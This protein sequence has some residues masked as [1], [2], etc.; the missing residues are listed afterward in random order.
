MQVGFVALK[1]YRSYTDVE[2]R[3][4]PGVNILLGPNGVG[5]TN[6]AEAVGY[7]STCS[8]HRV[9]A[10]L[11]LVRQGAN[12]A[13]I[14]TAAIR[15]DRQISLEIAIN[16]GKANR[17]QVSGSP[18]RGKD[19]VGLLRTV[20]FAPE[21]LALAKGD[22][23]ERRRFI[24]GVLIQRSPRYLSIKTDYDRVVRQRTALL[25]SI[26]GTRG[27][28]VRGDAESTLT[29]W[30]DQL[31]ESGAALLFGRLSLLDELA[32][33]VAQAYSLVAGGKS[34]TVSYQ[35]RSISAFADH[36]G[37]PRDRSAL[38]ELLRLELVNRRN[39]ECARGVT[40]VGP[41]RD[42][43]TL[44]VGDLLA[45]TYASHGE[46]WSMALALRLGSFELMRSLG[47][48]AGDPVL[49][50]DDVFAELD[51]ERRVAL[52]RVAAGAEQSIVTAAVA[53]DV[54]NLDE[55]KHFTVTSG[56]VTAND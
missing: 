37:L 15:D 8:S 55:A 23:G 46:C 5:K 21:D 13:I 14:R 12:Q 29:V 50:L 27:S 35:A 48:D 4:R 42:D 38:E 1:D 3:F 30:D 51:T 32:P 20:V 36:D 25:R 7:A 19:F 2:L 47:D 22:P 56:E 39:E 10:D 54:P 28:T 44:L 49:I 43:L 6:I 17:L 53:E 33:R 34:G 16:P 52:A 31:V 11:P 40:L 18:V 41:H 26:A 45:K 24:D 9:A